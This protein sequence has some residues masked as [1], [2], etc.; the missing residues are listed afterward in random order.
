M[1]E[2]YTALQLMHKAEAALQYSEM[3]AVMLCAYILRS[4]VTR[5]DDRYVSVLVVTV[6]DENLTNK[7][8]LLA[9]LLQTNGSHRFFA[10]LAVG[11]DPGSLRGTIYHFSS[12]TPLTHMPQLT[13]LV[14]S[15]IS[16][17]NQTKKATRMARRTPMECPWWRL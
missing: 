15:V 8:Y 13:V 16:K 4:V 11:A 9:V 10:S 7:K 2:A 3:E 5:L 14:I 6:Y 12:Q 17:T 1:V